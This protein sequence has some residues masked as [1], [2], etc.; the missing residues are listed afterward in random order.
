M[1]ARGLTEVN[2]ASVHYYNTTDELDALCR[3]ISTVTGP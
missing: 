3:A 2:R 1:T